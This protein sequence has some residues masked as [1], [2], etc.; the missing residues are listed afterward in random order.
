[1]RDFFIQCL[2]ACIQVY[3]N[4]SGGEFTCR[5]MRSSGELTDNDDKGVLVNVLDGDSI[6]KRVDS[7]LD[8][9]WTLSWRELQ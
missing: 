4:G 3:R 6:D 9:V 7:N 2:L 8:P 1:M 5:Q